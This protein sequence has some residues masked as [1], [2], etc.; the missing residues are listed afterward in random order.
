MANL[1][2]IAHCMVLL[3]FCIPG[4]AQKFLVKYTTQGAVS[5]TGNVYLYLSKDNKSPKDGNVGIESFP[6]F[7]IFVKNGRPNHQ[8]VFDDAAVSF[9]THLSDIERGEYYVQ[10]VWD[11]NLGGRSI[12]NSIGNMYSKSIRVRL[13]KD[14][15]KVF[16]VSCD[17]LVPEPG[18]VETPFSKEIKVQSKLLAAFFGRPTSISAAVWLPKEYDLQPDKKFP[19]IYWVSGYGGDYYRF[20]GRTNPAG[21]LDTTACI[22]VFLDG[23]CP[24]G[25]SVYTN[26]ENNGPWGDAL[27]KE[28]IPVI[29][30]K[31]RCNSARL[32]FGHS[33]GGWTVLWLQT[34]Y[35]SV[36]TACWS[37]SPDPVD[38]R[39]FQQ[40]NLYAD[41]NMYYDKDSSLRMAAT[42]AGRIPWA[43]MKL[44]C[45]MENVVLRG[46]Q[47]HSFDA[48]FSQKNKDGNPRR[49]CDPKTGLIDPVTFDHW[50]NY[51]ISLY[52]RTN[53]NK[54]QQDLQGKIRVS[55][56]EQDNFLLNYAVH[57]LDDEMKKMQS[58]FQFAYYPGDHFTV[59][60]TDYFNDG[61]KFLEEK[62]NEFI[63]KTAGSR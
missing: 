28:L 63:H 6:C 43:S 57:L 47:M 15:T 23:N 53:W 3:S 32:L 55:V 35:P 58:G 8:V 29:E 7:R 60:S 26:S 16:S 36:F 22:R 12:A 49:I 4:I 56:G 17:S 14:Y 13:T 42:I 38:F 2:R 21:P 19:V 41:K 61:N 46:E 25:H 52:L 45:Q 34:K 33:S 40:I 24:L 31:F 48:V 5:F 27:I 39:S 1:K 37:S 50:K 30:S 20:S 54:L 62:Y 44:V 18:F 59:G 11:R 10:A 51:D 9:P